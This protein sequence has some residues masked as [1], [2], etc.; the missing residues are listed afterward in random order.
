[1]EVQTVIGSALCWRTSIFPAHVGVNQV[2][3]VNPV[4]PVKFP[5]HILAADNFIS[6]VL[7]S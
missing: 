2:H 6:I 7:I 4:D 3:P 1:V 5:L